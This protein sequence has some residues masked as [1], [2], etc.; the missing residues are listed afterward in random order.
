M[1]GKFDNACANDATFFLY[2]IFKGIVGNIGEKFNN[3]G[4]GCV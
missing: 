4:N 1:F 3:L 2:L